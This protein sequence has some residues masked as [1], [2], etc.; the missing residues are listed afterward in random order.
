[1]NS[2]ADFWRC[3][4]LRLTG[5][6]QR[7]T[8]PRILVGFTKG[9]LMRVQQ[10]QVTIVNLQDGQP[11]EFVLNRDHDGYRLTAMSEDEVVNVLLCEGDVQKLRQELAKGTDHL[12]L[13]ECL[14]TTRPQGYT[15]SA[16]DWLSFN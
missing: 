12:P 1:M 8:H 9:D 10:K 14:P 11:R 5:T 7:P 6:T 16:T 4:D 2:F 15:L 3:V 13:E